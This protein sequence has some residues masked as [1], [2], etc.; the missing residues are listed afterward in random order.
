MTLLVGFLIALGVGLTGVGAG[1][2]TAP[3][4]ILFFGSAPAESVGTALVFAA[5]IKLAVAPM[6]LL[7]RQVH[8][9]ILLKLCI[10]GIPG[11][12]G[13][14]FLVSALNAKRYENTLLL[15]VG[16]TVATLALYT[17]FHSV[18]KDMPLEGRDRSQWLPGIAAGIGAEV[19]VSSAGAGALG[20]LALLHLTTLSPAKVVGTDMLF[21]LV[22]SVIG[23]GFHVSAGHYDSNV[24]GKL[25]IGGVVGVFVGANLSAILPARPLRIALSLCLSALG[26]QLCWKGIF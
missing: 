10:G 22:V 2:V 13:G 16:V 4:L 14:V 12:I 17:L 23:G 8:L 3:V 24:L 6:Y 21:G 18:R 15:L 9:K 5:V 11:V 26:I 19:G 1:A 20:S 7:R 25:L